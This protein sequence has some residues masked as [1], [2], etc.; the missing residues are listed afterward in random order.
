MSRSL[1]EQTSTLTQK[2][3]H[4]SA[5]WIKAHGTLGSYDFIKPG[6]P[7]R[8]DSGA[9]SGERDGSV[10][11][12]SRPQCRAMIGFDQDAPIAMFRQRF[13]QWADDVL[14]DSLQCSHF[15]AG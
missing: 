13:E 10:S 15:F 6:L 7:A 5:A 12:G 1:H 3:L 2:P 11:M 8:R 14:V 4:Q 9:G